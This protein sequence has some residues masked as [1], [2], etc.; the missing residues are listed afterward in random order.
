VLDVLSSDYV[1]TSLL[2][3]AF[4]LRDVVSIGGLPGAVRLVSK[5]PADAVG[6]NDRGEIA[7]M[8]RA[9]LIRVDAAS[10]QPVVRAAW[11]EGR[12]VS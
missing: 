5:N 10:G 6:F 11:R 9:D 3:A 7:V 2:M 4:A 8:K 12:R 1:P